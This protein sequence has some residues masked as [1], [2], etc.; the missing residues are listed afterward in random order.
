VYVFGS[1]AV[2]CAAGH[3]CAKDAV[4]SWQ[5]FWCGWCTFTSGLGVSALLATLPLLPDVVQKVRQK[6][7]Q[8]SYTL[9]ILMNT[10]QLACVCAA[11][12]TLPLFPQIC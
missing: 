8:V 3:C 4:P 7:Q 5:V 2:V 9:N 12:R 6:Q 10:E 11:G 1:G